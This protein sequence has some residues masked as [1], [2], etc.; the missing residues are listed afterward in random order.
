[1]TRA[2]NSGASAPLI[3][4]IATDADAADAAQLLRGF[5]AWCRVRYAAQPWQVD[6]YFD[7][8]AWE[9]E[10]ADPRRHYAPPAGAVLLA[11]V[12]GQA[13]GCVALRAIGDGVAEM[14]RL[15]VDDAFRG[16]GIGR[17]LV[18]ASIELAKARGFHTMRLETGELQ[19]ESIA[20]YRS[21]GFREIP[22]YGDPPPRLVPH[23]LFMERAL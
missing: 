22:P 1:M 23:L 2:G 11:R 4:E 18:A 7:P 16:R 13:A 19:P 17:R 12:D 3:A 10:L 21:F 5:M 8:A 15:Y 9:A 14:K 20:L 6:I